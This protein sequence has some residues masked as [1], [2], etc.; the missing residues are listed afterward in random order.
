V[1][2]D[3]LRNIYSQEKLKRRFHS[4]RVKKLKNIEQI[5]FIYVSLISLT[6][7]REIKFESLLKLR[8]LLLR[9]HTRAL[10]EENDTS[11][12]S[13]R[14]SLN[15]EAHHIRELADPRNVVLTYL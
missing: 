2:L 7:Q 11:M 9:L 6:A 14:F 1:Q 13:S 3:I 12:L 15:Y 5:F 10:N 4:S 8:S